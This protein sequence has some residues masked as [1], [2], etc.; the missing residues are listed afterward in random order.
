V[1]HHCPPHKVLLL[2]KNTKGAMTKESILLIN[3]I[4]L[5]ATRARIDEV[6]MNTTM[7]AALQTCGTTLSKNMGSNLL[8]D[9]STAIMRGVSRYF[10]LSTYVG[11]GNML[12]PSKLGRKCHLHLH[13]VLGI[14]S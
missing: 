5:P 14:T 11:N 1:F 4:A 8:K 10:W 7:L 3:K 6:S 2:L 13:P 9:A 12:N